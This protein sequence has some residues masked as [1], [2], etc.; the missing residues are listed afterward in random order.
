MR[1]GQLDAVVVGQ[2]LA[3]LDRADRFDEDAILATIV[4]FILVG[5]RLA[6]RLAA[7][8]DPARDVATVVGIDHVIVVEGKQKGVAGF[9]LIGVLG[10]HVCMATQQALVLDDSFAFFDRRDGEYAIA[11]DGRAAGGDLQW[12]TRFRAEWIG[13]CRRSGR[14]GATRCGCINTRS[15]FSLRDLSRID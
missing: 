6:I 4:A 5:Q 9:V 8:V 10:I 12:H 14:V 11:M 3:R 7:V 15:A 2:L 13:H 1:R